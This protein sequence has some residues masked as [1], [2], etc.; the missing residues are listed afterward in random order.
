MTGGLLHRKLVSSQSGN[1]IACS[2]KHYFHITLVVASDTRCQNSI[3]RSGNY[4]HTALTC[5]LKNWFKP[6]T[7]SS[8]AQF[9]HYF[10][11]GVSETAVRN[12]FQCLARLIWNNPL[13]GYKLLTSNRKRLSTTS[14]FQVAEIWNPTQVQENTGWQIRESFLISWPDFQPVFIHFQ[15]SNEHA[16]L[17]GT[18]LV[19]LLV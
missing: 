13:W 1:L 15:D 2:L 18:I 12:F 8:G 17:Y 3:W 6:V 10:V 4:P 7:F 11:P 9:S 14:L 5:H 16:I 19:V